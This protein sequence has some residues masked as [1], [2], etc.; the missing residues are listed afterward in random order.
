MKVAT[1]KTCSLVETK[2]K[3]AVAIAFNVSPEK[4]NIQLLTIPVYNKKNYNKE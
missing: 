2:A 4:K 1:I 3:L